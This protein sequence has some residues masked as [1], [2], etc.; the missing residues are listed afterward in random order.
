VCSADKKEY[1]KN[2]AP[3]V[4]ELDCSTAKFSI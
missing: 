1:I 4:C 2:W 3:R